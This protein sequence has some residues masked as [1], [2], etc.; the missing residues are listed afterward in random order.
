MSEEH[1]QFLQH[2]IREEWQWMQDNYDED[3]TEQD[4]LDYLLAACGQTDEGDCLSAGSEYCNVTPR[5]KPGALTLLAETSASS[6]CVTQG[7]VSPQPRQEYASSCLGTVLH[8]MTN[9][10]LRGHGFAAHNQQN[11]VK[12]HSG[13]LAQPVPSLKESVSNHDGNVP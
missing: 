5:L 13:L 4:A 7:N 12:E 2:R 10:L 8:R 11:C 6:G 3:V 9:S 1:D